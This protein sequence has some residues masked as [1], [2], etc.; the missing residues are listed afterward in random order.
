MGDTI[1]TIGVFLLIVAIFSFWIRGCVK[2]E[3]SCKELCY[4]KNMS[5]KI[6]GDGYYEELKCFCKDTKTGQLFQFDFK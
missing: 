4:S 2:M 3:N 1:K 6:I 5:S